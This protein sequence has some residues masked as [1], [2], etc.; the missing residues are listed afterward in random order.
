MADFAALA[1]RMI[2]KHGRPVVLRADAKLTDD[3][4]PWRLVDEQPDPTFTPTVAFFFDSKAADLL[5]RVTAVSRLVLS[6]VEVETSVALMP[7]RAADGSPVTPTIRMQVV[8][9]ATTW[10][11]KQV[12]KIEQGATVAAW[13][14]EL[15]N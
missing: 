3:A 15:G 13:V 1:L 7:A 14:L 6:T 4:K 2:S 5:A 10:E 11:I 8:D 9:D 12:G